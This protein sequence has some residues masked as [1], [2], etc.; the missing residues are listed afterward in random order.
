MRNR[1]HY[2]STVDFICP[3]ATLSSTINMTFTIDEDKDEA[4]NMEDILR[5][6]NDAM[7]TCAFGDTGTEI[8]FL[9]PKAI[10]EVAT[11]DNIVYFFIPHPE[12]RTTGSRRRARYS[13]EL[14]RSNSWALFVGTLLAG[15]DMT[16]LFY[17]GWGR[18]NKLTDADLPLG[19]TCAGMYPSK[20]PQ[21]DFVEI[22]PVLCAQPIR[23]SDFFNEPGLFYRS[24]LP[25]V[26][27]VQKD[28]LKTHEGAEAAYEISF[29][30][31]VV[32]VGFDTKSYLLTEFPCLPE[33]GNFRESSGGTR[34][35][36]E[37]F[38][39]IG[40]GSRQSAGDGGS[41]AMA[42]RL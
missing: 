3:T 39:Y 33:D 4:T 26:R 30:H 18:R 34:V 37:I 31:D 19:Y 13:E 21:A 10:A 1:A 14:Y 22:E 28:N 7:Q 32:G 8:R 38:S 42:H 11:Q 17:L 36:W 16:W 40:D 41:C 27:V 12:N 23:K 9:T 2:K 29:N 24:S 35:R 15:G 5:Y 25:F 20:G 6:I